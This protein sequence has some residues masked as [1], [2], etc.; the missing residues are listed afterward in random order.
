MNIFNSLQK[1]AGKWAVSGSRAFSAEEKAA[2]ASATVVDSQYGCSVCF[3][4]NSG[5]Q[6][7]IPLSNTSSLGVGDSVD[8]DKAKL[9]TLSKEGEADINRVEI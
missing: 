7:F 8:L 6:T 1:Y 3:H 9:L 4:M 2:V 5:G